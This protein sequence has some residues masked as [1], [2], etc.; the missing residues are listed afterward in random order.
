[1]PV[2]GLGRTAAR[3]LERTLA[4]SAH[5]GDTRPEGTRPKDAVAWTQPRAIAACGHDHMTRLDG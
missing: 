5:A 1:M 2:M 3:L 4:E